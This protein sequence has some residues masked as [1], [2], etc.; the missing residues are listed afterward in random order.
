MIKQADKLVDV[1][2][3]GSSLWHAP[4]APRPPGRFEKASPPRAPLGGPLRNAAPELFAELVRHYGALLDKA[5]DQRIHQGESV[6]TELH[7][8]SARL[9]RLR[10]GAR[11][12]IELHARTL[13]EKLASAPPPLTKAYVEEGRLVVLELMGRL[14]SDYRTAFLQAAQPPS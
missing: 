14:L 13:D 8:L 12:V 3:N 10:A 9:K 6:S 7:D 4:Q 11:D 1:K 2:T 5:V